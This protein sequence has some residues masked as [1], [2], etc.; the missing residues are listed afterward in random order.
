M[1]SRSYV[2]EV[3]KYDDGALN[4]YEADL[5]SD[6]SVLGTVISVIESWVVTVKVKRELAQGSLTVKTQL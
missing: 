5:K 6:I 2:T 3:S 1:V 4:L